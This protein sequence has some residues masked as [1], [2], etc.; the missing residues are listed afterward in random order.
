MTASPCARFWSGRSIRQGM[1]AAMLLGLL[2][3][4]LPATT[5]SAAT[6]FTVNTTSDAP[7]VFPGDGICNSATRGVF[8]YCSLRAAITEA[9]AAS[10][11]VV[12][13]VPAGAFQLNHGDLNSSNNGN[14]AITGNVTITGAG[15]GTTTIE[16]KLVSASSVGTPVTQCFI[17]AA[18]CVTGSATVVIAGVTIT[19]VNLP[20]DASAGILNRGSLTIRDSLVT[21]NGVGVDHREAPH[22]L[23]IVRTTVANNVV[24]IQSVYDGPVMLTDSTLRNNSNAG[25]LVYIDGYTPHIYALTIAGSTF[26]DNGTDGVRLTLDGP[27]TNTD[28]TTATITNS[29]FSG[30]SQAGLSLFGNLTLANDTVFG[31]GTGL[32]VDSHAA[33]I[34]G[35]Y[36]V[37]NTII[38]NNTTNCGSE[39][40]SLSSGGYNLVNGASCSTAGFVGP[41][42]FSVG[43]VN[44][45]PLASNGGPTQT[46]LPSGSSPAIE[47]IPIAGGCNNAGLTKDQRGYARP[48][49]LRCD[50]GSVE[51]TVNALPGGKPSGAPIG[52]V[53]N[54][55]PV[56]QAPG[57]PQGAVPNPLPQPRP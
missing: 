36:T 38:A 33:A 45:G 52:S 11:P 49:G 39:A 34:K 24:G 47:R 44:L 30:N 19:T 43:N 55:L 17:Q 48:I 12:I 29:T 5:V 4:A 50:I 26:S 2:L 42:D 27:D 28:E 16:G 14:L 40:Q 25:L 10:G 35:H 8:R 54:P 1:V 53:P 18:L 3:V 21:G 57:A 7:D 41:N 23:T 31:N 6:T 51:V 9:N 22:P 37:R 46:H 56:Q 13:V 32:G 15:A 20:P